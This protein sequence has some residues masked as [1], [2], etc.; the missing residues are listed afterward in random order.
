MGG[1]QLSA[2]TPGQAMTLTIRT[3]SFVVFTLL[4]AAGLVAAQAPG[5]PLPTRCFQR[6]GTSKLRH[7]SRILC[8]A[9]SPNAQILAAGGGN[10]PVRLWNPKTGE[11]IRE[12]NE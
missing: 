12:I 3:R 10:D 11:L 7:G 6:L 8:L 1:R 2:I 9:Y 4:A 5:E